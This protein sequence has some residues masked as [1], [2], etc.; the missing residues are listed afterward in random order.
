MR[1]HY[2][3][4]PDLLILDLDDDPEGAA[5]YRE[6]LPRIKKYL[7]VVWV[8]NLPSVSVS[9]RHVFI[10]LKISM[11]DIRRYALQAMLGSDRRREM[12]NLARALNG[13]AHPDLV[14]SYRKYPGLTADFV[15][16]CPQTWQGEP[17]R[18]CVHLRGELDHNADTVWTLRRARGVK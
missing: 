15:C 5:L 12:C 17:L 6:H 9:H 2:F 16:N 10:K 14:V 7:G 11:G 18:S 8:K 4:K 13:V 1:Y 3:G